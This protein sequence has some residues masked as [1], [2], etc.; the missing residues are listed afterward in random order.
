MRIRM[1]T[2][3]S[4]Q[5][6]I[7]PHNITPELNIK[8]TRIKE[9]NYSWRSS[10]SLN[11]FSLSALQELYGE[12]CGENTYWWVK[13]SRSVHAPKQPKWQSSTNFIRGTLIFFYCTKILWLSNTNLLPSW[14][15]SG[16]KYITLFYLA[17]QGI[18]YYTIIYT[19]PRFTTLQL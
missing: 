5:L 12:Q 4:D 16:G 3:K 9:M 18:H 8:V 11:K 17:R 7:S 1:L 13:R 15:F 2:L 14:Y 19:L 6:L 10:W